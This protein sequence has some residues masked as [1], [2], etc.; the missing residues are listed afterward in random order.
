MKM[1]EK[2]GIEWTDKTWNPWMGCDKVSA[3]C[4]NCYMFREMGRYHPDAAP[5]SSFDPSVV[6][7]TSATTFLKP[8][9]WK[10][11]A[12]IF[13]CSWS[14]FFHEDADEWR[15]EAWDI[16]RDNPHLTFQILTKRPHNIWDRLPD[17]WGD[18]YANV[19]RFISV[20]PMLGPVLFDF[21]YT[22]DGDIHWVI[23]GAESG[24]GHRDTDEAW[25]NNLMIQCDAYDIP[26]FVKQLWQGGKLVK[27][28]ITKYGQRLDFPDG[29]SKPSGSKQTTLF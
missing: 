7:R 25:V 1:G 20:E 10:E 21:G 11:P 18:G 3:G 22:T 24:P 4:K 6:S 8:N 27:E 28:P 13:V 9:K 5:G 26:V 12:K 17:D 2:T 15:D 14:D 29:T 19:I 23:I 16:I